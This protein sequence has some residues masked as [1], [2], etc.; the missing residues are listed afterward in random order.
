MKI[1]FLVTEDWYFMSHR[2]DLARRIA[3]AGHEVV[4]GTRINDDGEV[5][6]A[7][8][9]RAAP[10]PFVRSLRA[11]WTDLRALRAVNALIRDE[12]PDI[13]HLVSLKPILLGGL[14]L[15]RYSSVRG[16][17]VFRTSGMDGF[18]G[19]NRPIA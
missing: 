16:K 17:T 14:A 12:R 13:V 18:A 8:G 5:L 4:I 6:R 10:V 9:F 15:M 11:P 2:A 19:R 7:A 3:A 1:L